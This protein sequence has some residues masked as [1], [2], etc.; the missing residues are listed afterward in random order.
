MVASSSSV[1]EESE[2][3][4]WRGTPSALA[5]AP[6]YVALL[7]GL[8]VATAGLVFLG[9]AGGTGAGGR[10]LG[11]IVPWLVA[12]AWVGAGAV[13]LSVYLQSRSTRY[14]LTAQ[15]LRVTTGLLSTTTQEL[16]LRRV[17]D[18]VV[19]QPLFQRLLG[20]G[21]VMLISADASTPRVT[22]RSVADPGGLQSTI[23]SHVQQAYARGG[24]REIDVL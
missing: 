8:L 3:V 7:L 10:S 11:P 13:A 5:Q 19:V 16:E 21:H 2:P 14:T 20:L 15:R 23:R 4:V 6:T 18:T 24:V 12:L 17:R 22:L 1:V 9:R